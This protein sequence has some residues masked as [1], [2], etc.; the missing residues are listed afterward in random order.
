[1]NTQTPPSKQGERLLRWPDVK[2]RVGICRSYANQL[3]RE[4]KFPKPVKLTLHGRAVGWPESSIDEWIESRIAGSIPTPVTDD[5]SQREFK[6]KENSSEQQT[7]DEG[8]SPEPPTPLSADEYSP[9]DELC[10]ET[11]TETDLVEPEREKAPWPTTED[12]ETMGL[13]DACP[14]CGHAEFNPENPS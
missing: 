2:K 1:M 6:P 8:H 11:D 14:N 10:Y 4:G 12:L 9:W 3:V 13:Y 5:Q 7:V